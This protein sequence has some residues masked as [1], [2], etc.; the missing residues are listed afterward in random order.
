MRLAGCW[1]RFKTGFCEVA[2]L[3][4][5]ARKA[6]VVVIPGAKVSEQQV[7]VRSGIV[8]L[9]SHVEAFFSAM[10]DEYIDGIDR[11]SYFSQ[12]AVVQRYL[13][14]QASEELAKA[15]EDVGD[16]YDQNRRKQFYSRAVT[17]SRWMKDPSRVSEASKPRLREFYRQRGVTAVDKYLGLYC[18]RSI[19][20]FDWL[21][22]IGL[23]RGRFATVLEGLITARNEIAHGN[24]GSSSLGVQ[25][26]R[27]YLAV[28]TLMLR[29]VGRY[30][31]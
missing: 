15:I 6:T 19:K 2:H 24:D 3:T 21:G 31:D 17:A 10:A 23:D 28:I 20:F 25:D 29:R 9:A 5:A 27:D 30:I 11:R 12:P 14:L 13:A 8:L 1:S 22:S 18:S 4:K 26:L 16:G 7:L